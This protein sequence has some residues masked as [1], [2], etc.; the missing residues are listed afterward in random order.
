[1][2][3]ELSD[4]DIP[5]TLPDQAEKAVEEWGELVEAYSH[6]TLTQIGKPALDHV[7][8]EAFDLMEALVRFMV[9][10]GVDV[11]EANKRHLE[12]LR[13]RHG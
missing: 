6:F 9:K 4:Y 12:K 2:K 10:A 5:A 11:Q 8:E 13:Q 3:I 7:A 1:M